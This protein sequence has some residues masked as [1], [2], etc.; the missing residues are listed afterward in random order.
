MTSLF[1]L[2]MSVIMVVFKD[3]CCIVRCLMVDGG[4]F[5]TAHS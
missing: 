4:S 3:I 2:P 1:L 5:Y